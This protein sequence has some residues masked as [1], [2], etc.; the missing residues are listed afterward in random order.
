M[1][2]ADLQIQIVGTRKCAGTRKAERFFKERGVRAHFRDIADKALAAG[3]LD[4]IRRSVG[5]WDALVDRSSREF[6]ARN[7]KYY[8]LSAQAML[9]KYPL[10]MHTPVVRNGQ[11]ATVGVAPEIW[12]SWVD[13][14]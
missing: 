10:V 11:K 13:E 6:A 7:L 2:K 3:E 8:G 4:N 14:A 1:V 9:Q 12:Q 5:D